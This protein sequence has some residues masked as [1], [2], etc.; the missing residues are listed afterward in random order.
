[1]AHEAMMP[2]E[3]KLNSILAI[4]IMTSLL[5]LQVSNDQKVTAA[6]QRLR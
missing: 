6:L 2:V 1:M 3:F 5:G 4:A